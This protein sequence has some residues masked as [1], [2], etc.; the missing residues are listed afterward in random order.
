MKRVTPDSYFFNIFCRSVRE[1]IACEEAELGPERY[2]EKLEMQQY[3]EEQVY[4]F[5]IYVYNCLHLLEK[6]IIRI[7]IFTAIGDAEL[8]AQISPG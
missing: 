2:A 7:N 1:E 5:I 8:H 4:S 6:L 3:L